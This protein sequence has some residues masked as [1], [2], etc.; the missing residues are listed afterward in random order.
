MKRILTYFSILCLTAMSLDAASLK[1]AFSSDDIS[2][3]GGGRLELAGFAA[4]KQLSDGMH[5]PLRTYALAITD[6][7]RKVCIISNDLMEIPPDLADGIRSEISR[8]S[9]LS[10]ERILLHCIHTHSAPRI[11]GACSVEGGTNAGYRS[12]VF[13]TIVSNAVKVLTD[14]S[15]WQEFSLEVARGS[16]GINYNRCEKNG[17]VDHDLYAARFVDRKGRPI[18][19]R[20]CCLRSEE[21]YFLRDL[22]L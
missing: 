1:C 20:P 22:Y 12:Q 16:A 10:P 6:G 21:A 3:A 8:R 17:P 11:G 9:G 14:E 2:P 15:L 18:P 19:G 7:E 4:R 13:N 5:L